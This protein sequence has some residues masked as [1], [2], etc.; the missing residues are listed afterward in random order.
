VVT[1]GGLPLDAGRMIREPSV[2]P[3]D[4]LAAGRGV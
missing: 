3:A 1:S 2:R 4:S